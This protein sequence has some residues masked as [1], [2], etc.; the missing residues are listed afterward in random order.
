MRVE[1]V[2]WV[3]TCFKNPSGRRGAGVSVDVAIL[4]SSAVM[5]LKGG[6]G[7]RC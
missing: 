3:R 1:I 2:R 6:S 5:L 4:D 7:T